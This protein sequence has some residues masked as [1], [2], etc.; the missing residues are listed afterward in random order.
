MFCSSLN[1]KIN[2]KAFRLKNKRPLADRPPGGGRVRSNRMTD[3]LTRL[4]VLRSRK[5]R[6]QA[7][8]NRT[9]NK[10]RKPLSTTH[11]LTCRTRVLQH[12][13]LGSWALL[14]L[15]IGHTNR[16]DLT[17]GFWGLTP[18]TIPGSPQSWSR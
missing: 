15:R 13:G 14:I 5:L 11:V 18:L 9:P 3:R 17:F 4:K 6:M 16:K 2:K 1:I 10:S 8:K 7:V 12:Q